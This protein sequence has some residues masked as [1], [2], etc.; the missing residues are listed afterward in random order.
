NLAA[1]YGFRI[2]RDRLGQ[3][4]TRLVRA[5]SSRIGRP[6]LERAQSR[7]LFGR[8]GGPGKDNRETKDRKQT[9]TLI[10]RGSLG[11]GLL[12]A[13]IG[14]EYG[15]QTYP[16]QPYERNPQRTLSGLPADFGLDIRQAV[17]AEE[18][19][20]AHEEGGRTES[21]AGHGF[22]GVVHQALFDLRRLCG[23]QQRIGMEAGFDERGTD[24]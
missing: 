9:H 8:K 20:V 22:F 11:I 12:K 13:A 14:P 1:R 10:L 21:S 24:H 5:G 7:R 23:G 2:A 16:P 18:N 4:I 19:L 6:V 15:G 3:R 17:L